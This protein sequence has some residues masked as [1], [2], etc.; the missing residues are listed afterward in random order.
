MAF[1][2][3]LL[4]TIVLG[5]A[6]GGAGVA[7]GTAVALAVPPVGLLVLAGAT[8]AALASANKSDEKSDPSQTSQ[9]K[10]KS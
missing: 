3:P 5:G 1:H 10:P 7:T 2:I 4:G 9:N 6:A 8:V